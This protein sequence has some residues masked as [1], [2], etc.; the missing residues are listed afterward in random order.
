MFLRIPKAT[1][2]LEAAIA[3][4]FR[5]YRT[6]I[7]A[8]HTTMWNQED[9]RGSSCIQYK[10]MH[11]YLAIYLATLI[12]CEASNEIENTSA[13][14]ETKYNLDV[15]REKFACNGISLNNIFLDFGIAFPSDCGE[16]IECM[17]LESN[18]IIEPSTL[19]APTQATI[20][21]AALLALVAA[22]ST[23]TNYITSNCN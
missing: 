15:L 4:A 13:Y 9:Y 22:P 21:Q 3:A 11:Y 18:F 19:I 10:I 5:R 17:E 6:D 14:Y 8:L 20:T 23:C 7:L 16:G 12:Y 1:N 2:H